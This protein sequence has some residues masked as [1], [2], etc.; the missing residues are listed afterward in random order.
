ME[1]ECQGVLPTWI[2][3]K[4]EPPPSTPKIRK[5]SKDLPLCYS[6]P[7]NPIPTSY[8]TRISVLAGQ[9]SEATELFF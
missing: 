9:F 2:V 8:S 4:Q 7:L 3:S 5:Y 1:S 6:A